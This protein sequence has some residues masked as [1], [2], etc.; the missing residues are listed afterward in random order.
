MVIRKARTPMVNIKE[1]YFR[2]LECVRREYPNS[3]EKTLK[4]IAAKWTNTWTRFIRD[5]NS[6]MPIL[7]IFADLGELS[8]LRISN[9]RVAYPSQP[10][11]D[12][13]W[14]FRGRKAPSDLTYDEALGELEFALKNDVVGAEKLRNTMERLEAEMIDTRKVRKVGN[15]FVV[16]VPESIISLF[17]LCDGDYLSFIYRFGEVKIKK[18]TAKSLD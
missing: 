13:D 18:A 3:D 5:P 14:E 10:F 15:S 8:N 12:V 16:S 2:L 7:S 1:V 9:V 4:E 11:I 17:G 6:G